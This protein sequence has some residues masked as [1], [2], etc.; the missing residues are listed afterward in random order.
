M[1]TEQN[2]NNE[3]EPTPKKDDAQGKSQRPQSDQDK[4]GSKEMANEG[5]GSEKKSRLP[6]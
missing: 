1:G 3:T 6:G 2:K 4:S 5:G